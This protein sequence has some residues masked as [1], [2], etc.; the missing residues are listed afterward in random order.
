MK[1]R[2]IAPRQTSFEEL[3]GADVADTVNRFMEKH[4]NICLFV[5]A[6]NGSGST[7]ETAYF[8]VVEVEGH[9]EF[10]GRNY[11]SG[12]GRVGGVKPHYPMERK[13]LAEV[14]ASL[15]LPAGYLSEA[16]W[17]GEETTEEAHKRKSA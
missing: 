16:G 17:E 12:I 15:E 8:A 11:F 4:S 6:E 1:L 7:N 2:F 3:E 14:E 13:S 10:V 5:R 9:G